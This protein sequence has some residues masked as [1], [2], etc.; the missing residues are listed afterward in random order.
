MKI[1]Y[2]VIPLL[3]LGCT[4]WPTQVSSPAKP[5]V[6]FIEIYHEEEFLGAIGI[7]EGART[8]RPAEKYIDSGLGEMIGIGTEIIAEDFII[9]ERW[10]KGRLEITK[11]WIDADANARE[12]VNPRFPIWRVQSSQFNLTLKP[13]SS[14]HWVNDDEE[15]RM[16]YDLDRTDGWR[17][18]LVMDADTEPVEEG[19]A[20]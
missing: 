3:V 1:L 11:R 14:L 12:G 13:D 10:A 19:N 2:L 9:S 6:P 16:G 17:F 8:K 5:E 7:K 20:F 4:S 15:Q 18:I